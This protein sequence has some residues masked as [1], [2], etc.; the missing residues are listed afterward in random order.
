MSGSDKKKLIILGASGQAKVALDYLNAQGEKLQYE[1]I[2]LFDDDNN[3]KGK[4]IYEFEVLGGRDDIVKYKN[5]F[6]ECYVGFGDIKL[7]S[8]TV[9]M[10]EKNIPNIKFA[11]IIHPSAIIASN[12][13]LGEG[14]IVGMGAIVC[15]D[16]IIGKHCIINDGAIVEHDCKLE[17]FVN[18]S[19]GVKLASTIF[20]GKK[21]Y[22]GIG[23]C[24]IEDTK[25]GSESIIGAGSVVIK[26]VPNKVLVVGVPGIIKKELT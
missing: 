6:D 9:D 10:L 7:R 11:K 1:V 2:G 24:I 5:K 18:I 25:I 26:D 3:L 19:P 16:A 23:S 12:V 15:T 13:I 20:I 8:E 4:K 17:D 22:I 21:S 14:S